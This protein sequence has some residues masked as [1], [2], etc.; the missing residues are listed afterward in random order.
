MTEQLLLRVERL[1]VEYPG[2]RHRAPVRANDDVSIEIAPGETLGL[3]GE[4]GSGK[5]TLGDAILG[6][7]PVVSGRIW[8]KDED[9]AQASPGRRRELTRLIQ[10]IFQNPFGSLNPART[11]GATLREGL[12]AHRLASPSQA[13]Q[14]VAQWLDIVGL[15]PETADRYPS[16]FSGGQRQRVAIARALIMEPELVIC[17][18]AVSALDLSI[19][20]Q[21]LNLLSDL[22]R[23]TGLAYLFISHDMAV[24][25]HMSDRVAVLHHGRVV[26]QGPAADIV[27]HPSQPYTKALLEAVPLPDPVAQRARRATRKEAH[28]PTQ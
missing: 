8:F 24:V 1:V 27:N 7:A 12:L 23:R 2:G 5:S 22:K 13:D 16:D 15:P 14:R 4:S 21:V 26:E 6:F 11:I 18:E 28:E 3:V 20:A 9:I 25:E 17:D 10:P 19:Q